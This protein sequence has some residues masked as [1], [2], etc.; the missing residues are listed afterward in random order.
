MNSG[1]SV[2]HRLAYTGTK[3]SLSRSSSNSCSNLLN[4]N[5]PQTPTNQLKSCEIDYE[6]A[7]NTT[8]IDH[9]NEQISTSSN[10]Y[11]RSKS[12]DTRAR[13][14]L[15]Q[16]RSNNDMDEATYSINDEQQTSVPSSR[17]TPVNSRPPPRVPL[18]PTSAPRTAVSKRST[19]GSYQKYSNGNLYDFDNQQQEIEN[20]ENISVHDEHYQSKTRTNIPVHRYTNNNNIQS[21]PSTSS[22]N[23][24]ISR[25]KPPVSTPMNFDRRDSNGSITDSNRFDFCIY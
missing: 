8:I 17:F 10:K 19:N 13:L 23:N 14:K 21:S 25:T 12:V 6:D 3:A 24:T 18:T 15:A 7:P 4:K 9:T 20:E 2:F 1:D 11:Q 16:S 22:V 5:V